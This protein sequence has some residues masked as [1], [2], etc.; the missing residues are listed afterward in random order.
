MLRQRV[1]FIR[2]SLSYAGKN[3]S[4]QNRSLRWINVL[5]EERG[6]GEAVEIPTEKKTKVP[7]GDARELIVIDNLYVV[8]EN[9]WFDKIGPGRSQM[10]CPKIVLKCQAEKPC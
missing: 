10:V 9:S 8:R 5:S 6:K 2:S 3:F 7:E 4:R 1:S